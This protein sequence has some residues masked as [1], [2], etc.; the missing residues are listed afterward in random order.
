MIL[1][2]HFFISHI[3][4]KKFLKLTE[5]LSFS[6]CLRVAV[7]FLSDRILDFVLT[8]MCIFQFGPQL[9]NM[10]SVSHAT[11]RKQSGA[12]RFLLCVPS[13]SPL[14]FLTETLMVKMVA[15]SFWY[16]KLSNNNGKLYTDL[17][18]QSLR[19]K[20]KCYL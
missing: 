14:M 3:V 18:G 16:F 7:S 6:G 4:H 9:Y 19:R 8:Y 11:F 1:F 17:D 20:K 13:T 12:V 5:K 2:I 10:Y 15:G